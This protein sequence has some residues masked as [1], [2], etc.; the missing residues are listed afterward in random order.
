MNIS[1]KNKERKRKKETVTSTT[2]DDRGLERESE[3]VG[4]GGER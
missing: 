2:G 3:R 1:D 4:R